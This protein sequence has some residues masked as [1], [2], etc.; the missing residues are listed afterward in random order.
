MNK[1]ILMNT[2]MVKAILDGKKTQTRRIIDPQP[3]IITEMDR[4]SNRRLKLLQFGNKGVWFNYDE[5]KHLSKYQI[6]D[7]LWVREIWATMAIFDDL[8][9]RE[10]PVGGPIWYF[11]TLG[12]APTNCGDDKGKQRPSIHMPSW[13]SR[14]TLEITDIKV[15]RVQDITEE[16]AKA[17]GVSD[18]IWHK[19][20]AMAFKNLLPLTTYKAGFANT[21]NSLSSKSGYSWR[22][23]PYVWVISFKRLI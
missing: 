23:N 20:E 2:K 12:D 10:V 5:S 6:G 19:E 11:D 14:I 3:F 13:V 9:P 8:P 1:P 21:W 17:E 22:I 7:K 4:S 16:E 18:V 15:Q